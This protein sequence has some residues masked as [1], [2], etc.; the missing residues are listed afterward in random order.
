MLIAKIQPLMTVY[1]LHGGQRKSSNHIC[2]FWMNTTR[3]ANELPHLP[4]SN[5][6]PLIVYRTNPSTMEHY[7]FIVSRQ[8]IAL[9]L[10]WLRQ[11][12]RWYHD[13][14]ISDTALT[15]LPENGNLTSVFINNDIPMP[16]PTSNNPGKLPIYIYLN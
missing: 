15:A 6:V 3:I 8:R 9:A 13:I 2:N 16:P 12:H 14:I 1:T 11:H 7:D 5:N 10:L 4:V